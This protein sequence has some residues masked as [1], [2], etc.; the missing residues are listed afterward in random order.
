M[1]YFSLFFIHIAPPLYIYVSMSLQ[2]GSYVI[3]TLLAVGH[4][5]IVYT[6]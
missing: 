3:Q 1:V 5:D 6:K 2:Y 4:C